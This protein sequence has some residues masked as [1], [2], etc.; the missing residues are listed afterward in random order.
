VDI[1]AAYPAEHS[2]I[3]NLTVPSKLI[4][5]RD[6]VGRVDRV[7][8]Q[9]EAVY[10]GVDGSVSDSE[11]SCDLPISFALDGPR[12]DFKLA[13]RERSTFHWS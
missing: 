3:V 1:S 6:S 8:L 7:Q 10:V 4:A 9:F 12:E 11:N 5:P 2:N 13:R